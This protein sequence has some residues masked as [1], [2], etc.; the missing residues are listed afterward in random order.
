MHQ[1]IEQTGAN[2]Q[3]HLYLLWGLEPVLHLERWRNLIQKIICYND[4]TAHIE[5]FQTTE[6][7]ISNCKIEC[8]FL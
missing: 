2:K 5:M 4:I 7:S 6:S 8:K 1:Y 3:G